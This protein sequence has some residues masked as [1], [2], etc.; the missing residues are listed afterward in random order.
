MNGELDRRLEGRRRAHVRNRLQCFPSLQKLV[1]NTPSSGWSIAVYTTPI[2]GRSF[3]PAPTT[4]NQMNPL[5]FEVRS[6]LCQLPA[7]TQPGAAEY[8]WSGPRHCQTY[9]A[10]IF[11]TTSS[12]YKLTVNRGIRWELSAEHGTLQPRI[13]WIASTNG[14]PACGGLELGS[15]ICSS[16]CHR[17]SRAGWMTQGFLGRP[18]M[19]GSKITGRTIQES[20][21]LHSHRTSAGNQI[22]TG[23]VVRL[24]YGITGCP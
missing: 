16:R 17:Q 22:R 4:V 13:F 18:A 2:R 5:N 7:G 23:T 8:Q 20:Y 14:N 19:M 21:P 10:D 15:R 6:G 3:L 11:R 1:A 24:S 9:H 12:S